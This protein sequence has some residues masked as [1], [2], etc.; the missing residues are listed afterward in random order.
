MTQPLSIEVEVKALVPA[1]DVQKL[2]S[3]LLD[4]GYKSVQ[5]LPESQ[6]N[7]YYQRNAGDVATLMSFVFRDAKVPTIPSAFFETKNIS[8]R[9]RS[10]NGGSALLVL[11]ASLDS[12][13]SENG[14]N[15]LE[16]QYDTGL[17]MEALDTRIW[18]AGFVIASK[19][20][21]ERTTYVYGAGGEQITACLDK[22]AGYS[23]VLELEAMLDS[24]AS[25]KQIAEQH[26]VLTEEL[27][28]L[29]L[30][31]LPADRLERMFAH[32]Q[33]NWWDYYGTDKVFEVL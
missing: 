10:V 3:K 2:R 22:N 15:R 17:S 16:W 1:A 31:E 23:Y 27:A 6:L 20:S 29:G 21:R 33:A 19:W 24:G 14:S 11:K 18:N 28:S 32:Y 5:A 12:G 7:W 8:V 30:T 13:T 9:T 4:W 26:Y 25:K